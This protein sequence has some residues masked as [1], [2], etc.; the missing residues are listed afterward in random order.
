ME[1][2]FIFVLLDRS[3][4][5]RP[6][7]HALVEVAI[8]VPLLGEIAVEFATVVD[9]PFP[10]GTRPL[11]LGIGDKRDRG[12]VTLQLLEVDV[13]D[14]DAFAGVAS[15]SPIPIG[16]VTADRLR[17]S[18][19]GPEVIDCSGLSVEATE[20]RRL[21]AFFRGKNVVVARYGF[22]AL[23]PS[24]TAAVVVRDSGVRVLFGF[25]SVQHH[26]LVVA[27]EGIDREDRN[28]ARQHECR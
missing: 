8:G 20:D 6:C 16:V 3:V 7:R 12:T 5:T 19:C 24:E 9:G 2:V 27:R 15:A 1:I 4:K 22:G 26:L 10:V 11:D 28:E 18:Q 14:D 21:L 25:D 23:L 13:E 17:Q